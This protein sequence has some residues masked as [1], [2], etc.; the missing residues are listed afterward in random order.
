MSLFVVLEISHSGEL[1]FHM[2]PRAEE[3]FKEPVAIIPIYPSKSTAQLIANAL[4][5]AKILKINLP[6]L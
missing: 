2:I 4:P 1:S 6:N 5:K 3:A